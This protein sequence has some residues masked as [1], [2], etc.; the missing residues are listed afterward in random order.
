[1]IGTLRSTS[2]IELKP[3]FDPVFDRPI[4]SDNK[5]LS[6]EVFEVSK[7]EAMACQIKA[8]MVNSLNRCT[9][10]LHKNSHSM[11]TDDRLPCRE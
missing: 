5:V 2:K 11:P 9:L 4:K 6:F 10:Q 7:V 3:G 8:L 1:M